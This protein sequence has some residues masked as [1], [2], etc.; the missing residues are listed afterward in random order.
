MVGNY[1]N[2][3]REWERPVSVELITSDETPGFKQNMG[4]RIMGA[5]TRNQAQK[6]IRIYAREVYGKNNLK[7]ELIPGNMKSDGSD[8]LRKYKTFVLRIGGNDAD[9]GRLRDPF[10]QNLVQDAHF[11]TQQH[12]PCVVFINGSS[13]TVYI[14]I[15]LIIDPHILNSDNKN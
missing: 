12:P 11:D 8:I 14:E 2:R 7:Y 9:F 3:G 10:L 5:S 6:S 1:T 15:K 4:M 13:V